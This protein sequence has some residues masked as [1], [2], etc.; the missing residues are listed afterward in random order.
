[1]KKQKRRKGVG[2]VKKKKSKKEKKEEKKG[3]QT[4]GRPM[5]LRQKNETSRIEKKTSL[6]LFIISLD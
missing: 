3:K 1:R 2:T 6:I 5:I 4:K